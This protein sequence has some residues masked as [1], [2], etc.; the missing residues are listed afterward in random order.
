MAPHNCV[1]ESKHK[2]YDDVSLSLKSR[3]SSPALHH[4]TQD[5]L[6]SGLPLSS[7]LLPPSSTLSA[8]HGSFEESESQ[9]GGN[10]SYL[11][12]F[13]FAGASCGLECISSLSSQ[14]TISPL[15][16]V[17]AWP[18]PIISHHWFPSFPFSSRSLHR[19]PRKKMITHPSPKK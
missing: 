2:A 14:P 3:G 6:W 7:L 16:T 18:T 5:P 11:H 9:R 4:G 15:L 1:H 12:T 19:F 10:G 17:F 13:T 8:S